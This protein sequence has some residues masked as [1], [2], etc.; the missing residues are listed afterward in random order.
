M[1][2][3]FNFL[4]FAET[5]QVISAYPS[6][7]SGFYTPKG[8]VDAPDNY[9][10]RLDHESY[11]TATNYKLDLYADLKSTNSEVNDLSFV[12]YGNFFGVQSDNPSLFHNISGQAPI[13]D[14]DN[15][16]IIFSVTGKFPS[17]N[18]DVPTVGVFISGKFPPVSRDSEDFYIATSGQQMGAS[19]DNPSTFIRFSGNFFKYEQDVVSLGAT[20]SSISWSIGHVKSTTDLGPDSGIIGVTLSKIFW[21]RA[22]G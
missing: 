8:M 5:G 14:R 21:S 16:T 7:F 11:E 1:S 6:Q 3:P 22:G 4:Q 10:Y 18:L 9:Y 17:S 2:R 15:P 20:L 13:V 12:T 19:F